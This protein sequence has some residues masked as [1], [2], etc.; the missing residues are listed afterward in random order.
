MISTIVISRDRPAQLH[1]LL[2]SI[3]RNGGNLFH[4]TVL[5]EASSEY[6]LEGYIKAQQFFS[7][8]N[9]KDFNFPVRW[10]QRE[11]SNI[12]EDLLKIL[13]NS[14]DLVCLF[15]DQNIL[16]ERVSSYK[17]IKKL[18]SNHSLSS[19]S[20]RLGNNTVLQNPY[21]QGN[22]LVDKPKEGEF[23]LE[24]FLIWDATKI[25]SYTN[26][27]M[28]FSTNGHI[29][30]E[31][32]IKNVLK[33]TKVEDHDNFELEVQKS[34]YKGSFAGKIPPSMACTE[35]SVVICNSCERISDS[36]SK[37]DNTEIGINHRYIEGNT[38][39]YD[40]FDFSHISKPYEDFTAFF[41]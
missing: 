30:H 36:Q 28:P 32:L 22:Y 14:R 8:K 33:R 21:E 5:F 26:F 37:Y 2:E 40:S 35:Y 29:Y 25:R 4:L 31:N 23:D 13:S 34:L 19:L 27:G 39:D 9:K 10:K 38:I 15:N 3:Q 24:R 1:L 12:N 16:F 17:K 20:L 41:K 6:F 7:K 11:S 18:F